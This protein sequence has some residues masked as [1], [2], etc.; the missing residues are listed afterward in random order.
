MGVIP[1]KKTRPRRSRQRGLTARAGLAVGIIVLLA[2]GFAYAWHAN[3]AGPNISHVHGLAVD[4]FDP[5]RIWVATH[6]GLLVW[7][8]SKG[9]EGPVGSIIDLMGFAVAPERDVLYASGHP[10]P[11]LN[12]PNPV[13]LIRSRDGGRSWEPVALAGEVDFHAM[14]VSPADQ[15]RIHG[16]CYGDG[17]FYRSDDGGRTWTR[18]EVAAIAGPHGRGP[19][20]L[21][22]HPTDPDTLLAAGEDGLLRSEDGGRT[23]QPILP[24]AV[25]AAAFVPSDPQQLL[26]Y[27]VAAGLVRS[28]D[29]GRTWQP[30]GL[31]VGDDRDPVVAIAVHPGEAGTVYVATFAG[32]LLRTQDGGRTWQY[33]W[34]RR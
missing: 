16:F 21:V 14:A 4:P 18:T 15:R 20:Q 3:N 8:E 31:Q 30:L 17:R 13:G 7:R 6:E 5:D 22:A 23:W 27:A 2:A 28:A 12:M 9:W 26:A 34:R 24:G 11:G 25:T 19:L 33:L 32:N 1:V 10:G 29:G